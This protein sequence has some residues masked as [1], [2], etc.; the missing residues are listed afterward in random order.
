MFAPPSLFERGEDTWRPYTE[1]GISARSGWAAA[2]SERDQCLPETR[3]P[4]HSTQ[5]GR[6]VAAGL[7]AD[8]LEKR[9][10]L[11]RAPAREIRQEI[12]DERVV[13]EALPLSGL[14]S[15]RIDLQ[16][17]RDA[18]E[19]RRADP[20]RVSIE[21]PRHPPIDRQ[22]EI[23]NVKPIPLRSPTVDCRLSTVDF[24]QQVARRDPLQRHR[25]CSI[26][27]PLGDL[28]LLPFDKRRDLGIRRSEAELSVEPEGTRLN[29]LLVL[30]ADLIGVDREGGDAG[31]L[32]AEAQNLGVDP[33]RLRLA[34][35]VIDVETDFHSLE[36]GEPLEVSDRDAVDEIDR[37]VRGSQRQP[38]LRTNAKEEDLEP[39]PG[40][41]RDRGGGIAM[42]ESVELAIA[43]GPRAACDVDHSLPCAA[44]EAAHR[45]RRAAEDP[46]E[47][48]L[49]AREQGLRVEEKRRTG[50]A[51]KCSRI[52]GAPEPP[53][54][55]DSERV[56]KLRLL[57]F[58]LWQTVE[59]VE[60]P[61]QVPSASPDRRS[62]PIPM[63]NHRIGKSLLLQQRNESLKPCSQS[64]GLVMDV[65]AR[66]DLRNGANEPSRD[67]IG[68]L[69]RDG[70]SRDAGELELVE[71]REVL[72]VLLESL[73]LLRNALE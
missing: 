12:E 37:G 46:R 50:L 21:I 20:L 45:H 52:R 18:F 72:A 27:G 22:A 7:G 38:G 68:E 3:V 17:S 49:L 19:R 11:F 8:D 29:R 40:A 65:P 26:T 51:Q 48:R 60:E 71:K 61:R 14:P 43:R 13:F 4:A 24:V 69:R 59:A 67:R 70:R 23:P 32:P 10:L 35:G 57:D 2:R 5:V 1:F 73:Y 66:L 34:E 9:A 63:R 58:A 56:E 55:D 16:L 62:Q 39:S 30:V 36:E 6:L 33:G 15:S 54:R 41:P 28:A 53:G 47:I 42:G 64:I 31:R 25:G 44:R